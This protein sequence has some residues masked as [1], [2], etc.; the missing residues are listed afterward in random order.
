MRRRR[1]MTTIIMMTI[2]MNMTMM[3]TTM[4]MNVIV[5]ICPNY[6]LYNYA[7][8]YSLHDVGLLGRL[9]AL[10]IMQVLLNMW[11]LYIVPSNGINVFVKKLMYSLYCIF[12][13]SWLTLLNRSNLGRWHS[14]LTPLRKSYV[15]NGKL[16]DL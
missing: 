9:V 14:T 4:M 11:W 5:T 16:I 2:K 7:V 10:D 13:S 1:K 3:T 8:L 15:S 12:T 6:F